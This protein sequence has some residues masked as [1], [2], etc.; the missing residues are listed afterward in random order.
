MRNQRRGRSS[1]AI[2]QAK[3]TANS[4]GRMPKGYWVRSESLTSAAMQANA[5]SEVT[6]SRTRSDGR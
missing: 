4:A 2:Q 6:T 5:T 1:V 3:K